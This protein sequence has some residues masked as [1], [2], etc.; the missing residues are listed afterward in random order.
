M[1]DRR[2]D[3]YFVKDLGEGAHG[4]AVI[5]LHKRTNQLYVAKSSL[6]KQDNADLNTDDPPI[7]AQ[8][9]RILQNTPGTAELVGWCKYQAVDDEDIRFSITFWKYYALGT[10]QNLK[11]RSEA[12]DVLIPGRLACVW[13]NQALRAINKMHA[14][15]VWHNDI[16]ADNIVFDMQQDQAEPHLAFIDFS[17]SELR[18]N[19]PPGS[20]HEIH[21]LGNWLQGTI[22]DYHVL[23]NY[24]L[25]PLISYIEDNDDESL[26]LLVQAG[27]DKLESL[28][29]KFDSIFVPYAPGQAMDQLNDIVEQVEADMLKLTDHLRGLAQSMPLVSQEQLKLVRSQAPTSDELSLITGFAGS[30][31]DLNAYLPSMPQPAYLSSMPQPEQRVVRCKPIAEGDWIEILRYRP[32]WSVDTQ[33]HRLATPL[34]L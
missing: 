12:D 19:F 9:T 15:G 5:V 4:R 3:F 2:N 6:I 31:R 7:D 8:I 17:I 34:A 18:S 24:W 13:L 23:L 32:R 1:R 16:A 21:W 22:S 25:D 30:A 10:L 33:Q 27:C 28:T 29:N 11:F 26:E 20:E 14:R